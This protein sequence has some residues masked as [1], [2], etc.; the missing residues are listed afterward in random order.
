MIG[1]VLGYVAASLMQHGEQR[2]KTAQTGEIHNMLQLESMFECFGY[3][4]IGCEVW[5]HYSCSI[6]LYLLWGKTN[7]AQDICFSFD[8]QE[9]ILFRVWNA[10]YFN[11]CLKKG[12]GF[13]KTVSFSMRS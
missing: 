8:Y 13:N 10:S 5:L 7:T 4:A 1:I 3:K 12:K 11:I 9:V 6:S 2:T